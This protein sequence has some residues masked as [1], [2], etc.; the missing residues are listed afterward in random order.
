MYFKSLVAFVFC[1]IIV[2]SLCFCYGQQTSEKRN[3]VIIHSYSG[4]NHWVAN[5]EKGFRSIVGNH[6]QYYRFYMRTK[7][8]PKQLFAEKALEALAYVQK[9]DPIMVYTT[10]DNAF[11]LVGRFV[12][13]A[14]P[15][16]FSGVNAH[17]REEYPWIINTQNITGVLERPLIKRSITELVTALELSPKK[18]LILLGVSPTA[19]AFLLND[20]EGRKFFKIG[21]AETR[22]HVSGR[23]ADWKQKIIKSKQDGYDLIMITGNQALVDNRGKHVDRFVVARWISQY[24]PIPI[25]TVHEG[26]IGHNMLIGGMILSGTYMGED[27]GNIAKEILENQKRPARMFPVIQSKGIIIFSKSQLKRWN[28]KLSEDYTKTVKLLD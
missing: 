8:L 2:G 5:Q 22:V 9:I 1:T 3:I 18:I 4:S 13:P 16:V 24:S 12:N 26:Q 10:D 28:L 17:L 11:R 6:Y 21:A 20:L 27:A 19:K 23:F 7:Q 14:V 15:V 25:F